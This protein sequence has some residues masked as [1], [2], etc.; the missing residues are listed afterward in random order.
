MTVGEGKGVFVGVMVGV[1]DLP[2]G[3][4]VFKAGMD[5]VLSVWESSPM[6][7]L[8]P[9]VPHADNTTTSAAIA[10]SPAGAERILH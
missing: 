6:P 8:L 5:V 10:A 9:A 3:M 1:G 2:M 7:L 4:G